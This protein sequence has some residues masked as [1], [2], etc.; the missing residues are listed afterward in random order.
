MEASLWHTLQH[1]FDSLED[2]HS[3]IFYI[4]GKFS[5]SKVEEIV[6]VLWCLWRRRNEKLWEGV[7]KPVGLS[8]QQVFKHLQE[9]KTQHKR[10]NTATSHSPHRNSKWSKPP[11]NYMKCNIDAVLFHEENKFGV[12]ACIHEEEGMFAVAATS[13]FHGQPT[14]QEAEAVAFLFALN[15]IK[16]QQLGNIVIETDCKAISDAFKAQQFDNFEAGCIL[17]ICNTQIS[18]IHNCSIQ[19]V[20]KQANQV[21]HSLARASRSYVCPQMFDFN[22]S[23]I[24]LSDS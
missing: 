11:I 24:D 2:M 1:A 18:D 5:T 8:L 9:W 7:S 16:E 6:T 17:K 23:C 13:W 20:S 21:A 14:P 22:P 12:A 4:L 10:P 19:F 3:I 15:G